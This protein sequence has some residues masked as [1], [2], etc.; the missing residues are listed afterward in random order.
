MQALLELI[1]AIV[2]WA[3]SLVLA[4]L[5][6]EVDPPRSPTGEIPVARQTPS[7]PEAGAGTPAGNPCP[8]ADKARIRRV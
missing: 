3:A 6:I 5:G 1:A 7:A 2:I 4:Q 8:D